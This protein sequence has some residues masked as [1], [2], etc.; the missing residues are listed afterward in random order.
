MH[1]SS[2]FQRFLSI[3]IDC[4]HA[5]NVNFKFNFTYFFCIVLL[6]FLVLY[7]GLE[8]CPSISGVQACVDEGIYKPGTKVRVLQRSTT[9]DF[10][11]ADCQI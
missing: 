4:T 9:K 11:L 2:S 6:L 7:H 3:A 10:Y 5:C 8:T 1:S